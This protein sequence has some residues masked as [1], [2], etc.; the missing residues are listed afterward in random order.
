[1][2]PMSFLELLYSAHFLFDCLPSHSRTLS[3][4]Y[5]QR[6][7]FGLSDLYFDHKFVR[8]DSTGKQQ[9]QQENENHVHRANEA[10]VPA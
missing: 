10:N 7:N 1:M 4:E 3:C 9:Q 2:Q 8:S 5:D 6:S